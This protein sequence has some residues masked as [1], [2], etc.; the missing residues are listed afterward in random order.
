MF[1]VIDENMKLCLYIITYLLGCLSSLVLLDRDRSRGEFFKQREVI[2]LF[3]LIPLVEENAP[4][5]KLKTKL[6]KYMQKKFSS[7]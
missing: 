7:L 4:R 6:G 1:L 5:F 2:S 3:T